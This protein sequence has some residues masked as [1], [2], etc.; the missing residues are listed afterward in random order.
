V[1]ISIV[2]ATVD[3][4]TRERGGVAEDASGH[5]DAAA[6]TGDGPERGHDDDASARDA[7]NAAAASESAAAATL[8]TAAEFESTAAV[9]GATAAAAF[10]PAPEAPA[11][12]A[13]APDTT[14][15]LLDL[16]PGDPAQIGPYT[17]LRRIPGHHVTDVFVVRGL[18]QQLLVLKLSGAGELADPER[19]N[20]EAANLGRV[21]S[22]RVAKVVDSGVWGERAY[23]VQ[24][25]IDGP[26]LA[27]LLQN[28]GHQATS[29]PD[30]YRIARGLAEALHDVHRADVVHRDVKPSNIILNT[31]RGVVLVDFGIAR[32]EQDARITRHGATLGT[33]RYM[34]PEQ[35]GGGEVRDASDVFQWGLVVGE[36]LLGSHPLLGIDT[37]GLLAVQRCTADPALDGNLGRLVR[38]ALQPN[39]NHR[40][41]LGQILAEL[42]RTEVLPGPDATTVIPLPDRRLTDLRTLAE[43]QQ[44]LAPRMDDALGTLADKLGVFVAA[45]V[46]AIV[47]GWLTGFLVGAVVS[48]PGAGA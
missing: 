27:D 15:P 47:L 28:S 42:D 44:Y 31:S 26:T 3:R 46:A 33:P 7:A 43:V 13:D 21:R 18:K 22:S 39:P 24:E 20:R 35:A 6:A 5:G 14:R 32:T 4:P 2:E 11:E 37:D 48:T 38:D 19:I 23:F 8:A 17:L 40:P 41:T 12:Q 16:R 36:A 29:L 34:S 45:V 9:A 1:I 25:F 10:A 30:A